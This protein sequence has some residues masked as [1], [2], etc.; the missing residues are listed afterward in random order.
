MEAQ[1]YHL[2]LFVMLILIAV[3]RW[4]DFSTVQ[5]IFFPL[6]LL[7]SSLLAVY[8]KH[9]SILLSSEFPQ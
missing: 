1:D 8:L 7:I 6:L 5:L 2:P 3:K 4:F 9:A